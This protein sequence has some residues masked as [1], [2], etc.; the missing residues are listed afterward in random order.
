[1][2]LALQLLADGCVVLMLGFG[3]H[4]L[5][6]ER[7]DLTVLIPNT[8]CVAESWIPDFNIPPTSSELQF[9]CTAQGEWTNPSSGAPVLVPGDRIYRRN[10]WNL[11][12]ALT[13]CET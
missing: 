13:E 3:W 11:Q 7:V 2:N 8:K 9:R 12:E 10:I 5:V 6:S 4:G 1:M